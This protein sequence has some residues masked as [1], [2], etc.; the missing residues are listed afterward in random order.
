[1]SKKKLLPMNQLQFEYKTP[2]QGNYSNILVIDF[3]SIYMEMFA[4][5]SKVKENKSENFVGGV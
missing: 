5:N 1:M 4:N 2:K 3:D